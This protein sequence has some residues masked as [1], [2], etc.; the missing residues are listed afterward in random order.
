MYDKGWLYL[1]NNMI[2]NVNGQISR[3]Y[4]SVHVMVIDALM[5]IFCESLND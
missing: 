3:A 5:C 1:M 4:V 2:V